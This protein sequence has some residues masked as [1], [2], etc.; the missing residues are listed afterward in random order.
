MSYTVRQGETLIDIALNLSGSLYALDQLMALNNLTSYT[1]EIPY[2][3]ILNTDGIEIQN[4]KAVVWAAKWPLNNNSTFP[5]SEFDSSIEY[6]KEALISDA[7]T[8]LPIG[9]N[10]RG[11]TLIFDDQEYFPFSTSADSYSLR[12]TNGDFVL[13]QDIDMMA[14]APEI[15][16]IINGVTTLIKGGKGGWRE[17]EI[18][19]PD[20][21]DYIIVSSDLYSHPNDIS[22]GFDL[23]RVRGLV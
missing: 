15:R 6:F 16:S 21:K 22:W 4:N 18:V 17:S 5:Q 19:I 10:L 14:D 9:T 13:I 8:L 1:E 12:T 23:V 20:D 3:T 7:L 11:C 2:G